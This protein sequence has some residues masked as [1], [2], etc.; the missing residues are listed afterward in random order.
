MR[1]LVTACAILISTSAFSKQYVFEVDC[2]PESKVAPKPKAKPKSKAKAVS[3]PA[4]KLQ[5]QQ[6]Q[7]QN[8]NVTVNVG[9]AGGYYY[10][11]DIKNNRLNF[12]LGGALDCCGRA[13]LVGG[14]GYDR[15]ISGDLWLGI[16][17]FSNGALFGKVGVEF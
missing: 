8:Q 10:Y 15:R 11:E 4:P 17:A 14:A 6:K 9:S 16:E 3:A 7:E 12:L 1:K 5:Q 13:R 2:C